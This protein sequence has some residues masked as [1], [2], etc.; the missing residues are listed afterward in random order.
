[1]RPEA[2]QVNTDNSA[3]Y[4]G[5]LPTGDLLVG[6]KVVRPL[7]LEIAD[8][9]G[10]ERIEAKTM[11]VLMCLARKEGEPVTR[12]ELHSAVWSDVVVTDDVIHRA[13]SILRKVFG[14]SATEQRVIETIPRVGYRLGVP[15]EWIAEDSV[16]PPGPQSK[17]KRS[18][19]VTSF[20][21]VLTLGAG[22]AFLDGRGMRNEP[23]VASDQVVGPIERADALVKKGDL[24][25]AEKELQRLLDSEPGQLASRT[26]LA[27]MQIRRKDS[28]A[29]L[30]TLAQRPQGQQDDIDLLTLKSYA[31]NLDGKNDAAREIVQSVLSRSNRNIAAQRLYVNLIRDV[32]WLVP[33]PLQFLT[34]PA[35]VE[36]DIALIYAHSAEWDGRPDVANEALERLRES[37]P[38]GSDRQREATLLLSRFYLRHRSW[39]KLIALAEPQFRQPSLPTHIELLRHYSEALFQERGL[40][41]AVALLEGV[42]NSG[43]AAAKPTMLRKAELQF[44][45]GRVENGEASLSRLRE[46]ADADGLIAVARVYE[47]VGRSEQAV[48]T[49]FEAL[50]L[51]PRSD[52]GQLSLASILQDNGREAEAEGIY[53]T[54]LERSPSSAF[55]LNNLAFLLARSGRKLDEA[56]EFANRAVALAGNDFAFLDT[57]GWVHFQLGDGQAAIELLQR[58]IRQNP[59]DPE[60]LHHA[61]DIAR[62]TGDSELAHEYY[63]HSLALPGARKADIE[64]KLSELPPAPAETKKERQ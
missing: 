20:L 22:V 8:D 47:R 11:R 4:L 5:D 26:R 59:F 29:A 28:A 32:G 17:K 53:R 49:S 14:D 16:S 62:S 12:E 58:A 6:T 60:I 1:M 44:R 37:L 41:A 2:T 23:L 63:Q 30:R 43:P 46:R 54:V 45:A 18:Q 35:A 33:E 31:L 40:A 38:A 50:A 57:L 52:R 9:I 56:L 36:Q 10:V 64:R 24:L 25:A 42:A 39:G 51:N 3:E 13:I 21:A 55:A 34:P 7:A 48:S 19:L 61:G 27:T 15:V